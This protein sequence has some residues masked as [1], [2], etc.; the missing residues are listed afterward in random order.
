MA[1]TPPSPARKI[2]PALHLSGRR[3]QTDRAANP[4]NLPR[5][6][7]PSE[8]RERPT[9]R[10]GHRR[11]RPRGLSP[12][13]QIRR[14]QPAATATVFPGRAAAEPPGRPGQHHPGI[15]VL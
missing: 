4:H 10:T 7:A 6:H 1:A 14:R 12:G 5:E 15:A 13:H 3:G 2:G 9:H 8:P 11:R